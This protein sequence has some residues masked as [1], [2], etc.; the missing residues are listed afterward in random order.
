MVT[1]QN[2]HS[3]WVSLYHVKSNFEEFIFTVFL[4]FLHFILIYPFRP[5]SGSMHFDWENAFQDK[6]YQC[7]FSAFY[8]PEYRKLCSL[9][10]RTSLCS[11]HVCVLNHVWLFATLWTV[12]RQ[13]PLCMGLFMEEYWS[14]LPLPSPG[15]LPS[16]STEP[17]SSISC[18]CRQILYHWAT[19]SSEQV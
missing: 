2:R 8:I 15:D 10:F 17:V 19:W 6:N 9:M 3:S 7:L 14:G 12:A 18:T 5:E 16:P 13:A 11:E 1:L 4:R